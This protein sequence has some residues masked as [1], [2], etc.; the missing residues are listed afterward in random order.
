[1]W[2]LKPEK[3]IG[4]NSSRCET[5]D[6]T[7][8]MLTDIVP[9]VPITRIS[10]LTPLDKL[11]LPA[12]S[13]VTPLARDLTTHLGKGVTKEGAK[14]SAMMEAVERVSA[15]STSDDRVQNASYNELKNSE[16]LTAVNPEIFSL[17][18]D[19]KFE[20]D[21]KY[22]WLTCHD[23]VSDTSIMVAADLVLSPP[24]EEMLL[25]VDTNGLASG[26]SLLEAVNHALCEVIERDAISQYEFLAKYGDDELPSV[27]RNISL[28]TLPEPVRSL[29]EK[30]EKF[31]LHINVKDITTDISISTFRA[32]IV[33]PDFPSDQGP[34]TLISP[35]F[36]TH[37]NST[38]A[39]QRAVTEAVQARVSYIQGARDAFNVLPINK[40]FSRKHMLGDL[41]PIPTS[42]FSS[43]VSL[44]F[45]NLLDELR[46]ILDRLIDVK[47]D[48]VIVC[49]LTHC[50]LNVPVVRVKVPGLSGFVL[51]RNLVDERCY[52]HIL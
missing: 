44:E 10:D 39:V 7:L 20:P 6:T 8:E 18:P 28:S 29:C 42:P 2:E 49:N 41:T 27:Y 43:V 48:Q 33:D 5:L 50:D 21:R 17:P 13:A 38:V 47:L 31:G 23:L 1:M 22:S 52:R 11:G 34:R 37:P 14:V 32:V 19:S 40:V 12:Y 3:K 9:K 24:N 30:I 45:E 4:I 26:N 15:E 36:G 51:N 46:K 35:G 25:N 16:L